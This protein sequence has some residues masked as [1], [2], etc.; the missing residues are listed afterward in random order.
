M[1]KL[2]SLQKPLALAVLLALGWGWHQLT[3]LTSSPSPTSHLPNQHGEPDYVIQQA[4]VY[5]YNE[6]GEKIQQVKALEVIS[7]P[8]HNLIEFTQPKIT[9]FANNQATWLL[10]SE[11][12]RHLQATAEQEEITWLEKNVV[13]TP[14]NPTSSYTPHMFT[15]NLQLNHQL[16]LAT[17]QAKVSLLSPSGATY[18]QGLALDF[19]AETAII[20]SQ[21]K[22]R[23]APPNTPSQP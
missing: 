20:E 13:L 11:E 12:G 17:T 6:L 21:V 23:Y 1:P 10:E 18:G 22:G 3:H 2:K 8:T 14:L 15:A 7:Y 9:Q 5:R 4:E 16:N 19:N